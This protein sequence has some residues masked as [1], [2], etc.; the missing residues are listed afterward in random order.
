MRLRGRVV[1]VRWFRG[2]QCPFCSATAPSLR[3]LD[4]EF[5]ARGLVVIGLY[6]D[7]DRGAEGHYVADA[8]AYHFGFPVARDTGLRTLDAW[9]TPN[10]RREFSSV[11]F[12]LD[13]RGRVRGVH[14]GGRYAQGD[15]DFD[16]M[17]AAITRLVDEPFYATD[18]SSIE[19]PEKT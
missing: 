19:K 1:L 4:A 12:L 15:A 6:N 18:S 5:R 10:A 9:W 11:S 13:R 8:F 16:A 3:A 7:D 14:Q 2:A 17:R